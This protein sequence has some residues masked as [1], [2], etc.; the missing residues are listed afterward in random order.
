MALKVKAVER[1]LKFSNKPD[2]PG[3]YRFVM[4]PNMYSTLTQAKV[5][6]DAADCIHRNRYRHSSRSN[7]VHGNV[8]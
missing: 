6:K 4:K 5:I 7:I 2:D 3:V 1:L 8:T